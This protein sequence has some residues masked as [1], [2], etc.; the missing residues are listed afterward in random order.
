MARPKKGME[1][2]RATPTLAVRVPDRVRAAIEAAAA[3]AGVSM[4]SAINSALEQTFCSP[5]DDLAK[6]EL[7]ALLRRGVLAGLRTQ[8]AEAQLRQI[9]IAERLK[10]LGAAADGETQDQ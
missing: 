2:G 1:Q 7:R 6:A 10:A 8:L 9:E 5:R 3:D 4:S